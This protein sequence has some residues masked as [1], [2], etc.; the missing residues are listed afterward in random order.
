M[1]RKTCIRYGIHP[2]EFVRMKK[3]TTTDLMIEVNKYKTLYNTL[4]IKEAARTIKLKVIHNEQA[5][6]LRDTVV[7]IIENLTKVAKELHAEG[8]GFNERK[9]GR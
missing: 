1:N 5:L 9:E 8:S 3:L 6:V 4:L 2:K 7:A